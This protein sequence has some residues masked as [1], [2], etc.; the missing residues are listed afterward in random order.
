MLAESYHSDLVSASRTPDSATR[1]A[2]STVHLAREFG[3][4]YGVDRAVD[5]AYQARKRFPDRPVL[6]HR[7]DHPQPARQR[8]A[9][10]P[11]HPLPD[12]SRRIDR[13]ADA[14]RRRHPAGVRRAPSSCS[15]QLESRGCTMV[16]TTCGSVLNVWKN[17]KRYAR[18]RLHLGHSRQVPARGDAGHRLAGAQRRERPLPGRAGPR[19]GGR[20]RA[21]TSAAAATAPRFSSGSGTRSRRASIPTATCSASAAPTRRR[22]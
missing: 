7:R 9:A 4:C 18:G 15:Q 2:A 10:R 11:G 6:P 1:P 3:F 16:D 13:R 12:R 5:Y 19:R 22:C 14:G 20:W 21:T 17:V 8:S